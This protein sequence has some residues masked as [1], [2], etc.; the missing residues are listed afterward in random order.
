MET[1]L[2]TKGD[3]VDI[4]NVLVK[5]TKAL[6]ECR[7]KDNKLIEQLREIEEYYN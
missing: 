7:D 6:N 4:T 3:I 1:A 5:N 2:L